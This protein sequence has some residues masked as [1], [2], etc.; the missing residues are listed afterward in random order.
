MNDHVLFEEFRLS[1]RVPKDL[2]DAD[3]DAIRRILE[4]RT[5][6]AALRRA[7]RQLLRQN[8]DLH[9]VRVRISV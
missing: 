2:D 3:S 5:F 1:F 9:P 8:P 4:S 6:R 7:V